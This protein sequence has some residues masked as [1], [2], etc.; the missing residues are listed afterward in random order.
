MGNGLHRRWAP[1]LC[2]G[3]GWFGSGAWPHGSN[4]WAYDAGRGAVGRAA[5]ANGTWAAAY[6]PG[7]CE[8]GAVAVTPLRQALDSPVLIDTDETPR[9]VRVAM[10]Q[11]FSPSERFVRAV[12]LSAYVRV[13]CLNAVTRASPMPP[14]P[15]IAD[16]TSASRCLV[17]AAT[18]PSAMATCSNATANA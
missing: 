11:R 6:G 16:K 14:T 9:A 18:A 15:E 8:Y 5:R 12:A 10:L 2:V 13:H 3:D 1:V 7:G 17:R 4:G